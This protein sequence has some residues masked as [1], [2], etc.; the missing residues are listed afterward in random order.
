MEFERSIFRVHDRLLRG[1]DKVKNCLKNFL[2]IFFFLWMFSALNFL[3]YHFKFVNDSSILKPQMEQQL[4]A[5]FHDQYSNETRE[6]KE[7]EEL[8]LIS[9]NYTN[10]TRAF[11]FDNTTTEN[12]VSETMIEIN[13]NTTI[14]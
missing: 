8:P 7:Y 9:L 4:K 14:K 12:I 10:E 6:W 13:K 5:Y 3:L 1:G 2:M 11:I